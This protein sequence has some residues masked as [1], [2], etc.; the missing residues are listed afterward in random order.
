MI[1]GIQASRNQTL[2]RLIIG[3]GI[4]GVGEVAA[5]D[6][7]KKY[8]DLEALSKASSIQL[9]QIEG[10]GPNTADAIVDWFARPSN[11]ALIEKFKNLGVWPVSGDEDENTVGQVFEGKTFVVT[12]TLPNFSR[13]QAKAYIEKYGGKVTDSVSKKT[14]YL[15]VGENAGSK[16][17][18]A[19]SLGVPQ[20]SE[21]ALL[22]LVEDLE[23]SI[24]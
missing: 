14:D 19:I 4:R 18:K 10:F 16:L 15:V 21:E 6:L 5:A 12:G 8:K 11:Q 24:G 23:K 7:A 1:D 3:L 17:D 13:D 20:L 22:K 2:A 9:Q